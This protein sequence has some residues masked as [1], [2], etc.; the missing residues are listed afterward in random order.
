MTFIDNNTN[1]RSVCDILTLLFIGRSVRNDTISAV[2][3]YAGHS[4]NFAAKKQIT[5]QSLSTA[6]GCIFIYVIA[7]LVGLYIVFKTAVAIK[8]FY[9]NSKNKNLNFSGL[10]NGQGKGNA[11]KVRMGFWKGNYN[12][13]GWIAAYNY[14]NI[15]NIT[16][17]PS[18]IVDY[19]E[20]RGVIAGG[21][22][23][24][25]PNSVSRFI[26]RRGIKVTSEYFPDKSKIDGKIKEAKVA[27]L[28]YAHSRGAHYI[29]VKWDSLKN[30]FIIY[31]SSNNET[32]PIERESLQDHLKSRWIITLHYTK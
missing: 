26:K 11:A 23:G 14:L 19:L 21:M 24:I 7:I 30:R 25:T 15:L 29:T 8:S 17:H 3:S 20:N 12:G 9:N 1:F 22:F 31:N 6:D 28:F 5:E 32:S 16:V 13:C 4:I 2:D 27:V 10:I 18:F